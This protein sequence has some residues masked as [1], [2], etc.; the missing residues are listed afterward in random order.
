MTCYHVDME[1]VKKKKINNAIDFCPGD[2][3]A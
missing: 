3:V 1:V 2:T